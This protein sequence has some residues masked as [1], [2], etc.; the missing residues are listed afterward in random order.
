[1]GEVKV[2][3]KIHG[4][5]WPWTFLVSKRL[6]GQPILGADFITHTHMVLDLAQ[7]RAYFSFAPKNYIR[8]VRNTRGQFCS[9]TVS[10]SFRFP[11]IQCCKLVPGQKFKLEQL[12]GQYSDVLTERLGMTHLLEYDI[13]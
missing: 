5:S 4:F 7:S 13:Q 3:L 8:F 11:R 12:I 10:L 2:V 1:V 6:Q 9:H